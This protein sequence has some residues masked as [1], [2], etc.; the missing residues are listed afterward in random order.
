[1]IPPA[2]IGVEEFLWPGTRRRGCRPGLGPAA[3]AEAQAKRW[4]RRWPGPAANA[5]GK[6]GAGELGMAHHE[7]AA[8][9]RA[10][11]LVQ[12]WHVPWEAHEV[13]GR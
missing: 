8:G 4:F 6:P 13:A 5:G 3:P 2:G 1:M 11:R 9:W 12:V 10:D 7:D